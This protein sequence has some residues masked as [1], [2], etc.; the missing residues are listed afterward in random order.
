MLTPG[1]LLYFNPF[2]FK[3]GAQPKAKYFVVLGHMDSD[4]IIASLPTSK[5]HVPDDSQVLRGCVNIPERCVSA[6]V[7]EEGD[8]VT[9]N[10]SFPRRTFIYGEQV[11]EY[12]EEDLINQMGGQMT[13]LGCIKPN[14]FQD[15]IQCLKNSVV[16]RRKYRN[17]L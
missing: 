7:F 2:V 8:T 10:F 13:E 16:L 11:D 6:Y 17:W 1:T 3:N 4:L 15:L 9:D 14:I 12:R 5:D